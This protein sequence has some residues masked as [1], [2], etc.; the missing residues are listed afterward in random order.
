MLGVHTPNGIRGQS[1]SRYEIIA[2]SG[3]AVEA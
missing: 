2:L 1:V 3:L